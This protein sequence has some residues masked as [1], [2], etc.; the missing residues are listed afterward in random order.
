MNKTSKQDKKRLRKF[1]SGGK[2]IVKK[3]VTGKRRKVICKKT[4]YS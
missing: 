2:T 3:R 4:L 1:Q